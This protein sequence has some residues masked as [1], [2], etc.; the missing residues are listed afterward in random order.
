MLTQF[1][2]LNRRQF[3]R[4][5]LAA[6]AAV[7]GAAGIYTSR[8]EP[9]WIELVDRPLAIR[10]LPPALSSARLV[11]ISDLHVGPVV[12]AAYIENAMD[13]VAGM[14]PD[15]I[16][17]TGDFMT[18]RGAEQVERT[19]AVIAKLQPRRTPTFAI[20]GNHDYGRGWSDLAAADQL[21][22]GLATLG[23]TVLRNGVADF[24]GLQIAGCDD[25]WAERSD[26]PST[27]AQLDDSRSA[28][29]LCHNPD[30]VDL[31]VWDGYEGWILA[32]HTHGGQCCVPGYGA[33]VLPIRNPLYASG[34][35]TLDAGRRLYVNRGLGYKHRVRFFSRPEITQF[36]LHHTT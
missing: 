24:R 17:A 12:D 13:R 8:F 10:D 20:L 25:W 32:G 22:D 16:L 18:C 1:T 2:R 27:I 19:L 29:F 4:R 5:S 28:I 23:V 30:V 14:R 33:P 36:H 6:S 35:V 15:A 9:H 3:L 7:G 26:V 31:P 34:E 11:Q 21:E